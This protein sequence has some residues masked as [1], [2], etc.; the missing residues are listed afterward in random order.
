MSAIEDAEALSAYLRKATSDPASIHEALDHVFRV[1]HKRA[2]SCQ[3]RSR[4]AGLVASDNIGKQS[5]DELF[6]LWIYPGAEKYEAEHPEMVIP[7]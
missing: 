3:S 6:A 2:S 5:P 4:A 7:K 1:R